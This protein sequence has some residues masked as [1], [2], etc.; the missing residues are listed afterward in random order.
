MS[1][2]VLG[3]SP[4]EVM[5]DA[6]AKGAVHP[7]RPHHALCL[8]FFL[9]KGYGGDFVAGMAEIERRLTAKPD[10]PVLLV[11]GTD[12]IC[13]KCPHNRDGVCESAEKAA[14]YDAE[15]LAACGLSAGRVL[16]W[17][18]L[19]RRVRE[20]ILSKRGARAKICSDCQWDPVC[21][22]AACRRRQCPP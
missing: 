18:E 8:A 15:C 4:L 16:P 10:T 12:L 1:G 19:R 2:T 7:M 20:N 6:A 13:S 22:A 17:K 5:A 3:N 21:R 14:R 11:D 9:G